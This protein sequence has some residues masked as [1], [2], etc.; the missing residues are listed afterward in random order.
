VKKGPVGVHRLL[1]ER[2]LC[3]AAAARYPDRNRR[4]G[5][6]LRHL[7]GERAVESPHL[8]LGKAKG[9]RYISA[10]STTTWHRPKW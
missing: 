7:A 8:T 10:P 3:L 4:R 5:I 2:P 9:E 1:S 6:V